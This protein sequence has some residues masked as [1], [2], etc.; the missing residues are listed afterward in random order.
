[1][2]K[3]RKSS[4]SIK[5]TDEGWFISWKNGRNEIEIIRYY[6]DDKRKWGGFEVWEQIEDKAGGSWDGEH[7]GTFNNVNDAIKFAKKQLK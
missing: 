2:W 3:L 4:K 7:L 1:M 5:P 6:D